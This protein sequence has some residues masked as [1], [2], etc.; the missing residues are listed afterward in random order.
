M[1]SGGVLL[2]AAKMLGV[3]YSAF[4]G[5]VHED[6]ELLQAQDLARNMAVDLAE[7][8]LIQ[9]LRERDRTMIIFTLKCLG[10]DRGYIERQELAHTL[11]GGEVDVV[12]KIVVAK[13]R[14]R[15][16]EAKSKP[17]REKE[18]AA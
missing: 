14:K 3:S 7:T 18:G 13:G 12:E 4:W 9:Y 2:P 1:K 15:G 6:E 10:K 16:A 8:G 11:E 5:W 17:R